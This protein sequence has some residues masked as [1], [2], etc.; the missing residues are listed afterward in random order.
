MMYTAV[1][2]FRIEAVFDLYS[3]MRASM[4]LTKRSAS[5]VFPMAFPMSRIVSYMSEI[6][7]ILLYCNVLIFLFCRE[8]KKEFC[9]KEE[10]NTREG[11]RDM[12]LS[13]FGVT[14]LPMFTMLSAVLA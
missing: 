4:L 1:L 8:F 7:F 12:I 9:V 10:A 11:R 2:G 3:F 6:E 14:G 13:R 5:D